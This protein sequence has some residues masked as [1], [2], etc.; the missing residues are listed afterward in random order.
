LNADVAIAVIL[1]A[2]DPKAL[3][4]GRITSAKIA[5]INFSDRPFES[6][7]I[8]ELKPAG[9]SVHTATHFVR[10]IK[11]GMRFSVLFAARE[12]SDF[13]PLPKRY[14][15]ATFLLTP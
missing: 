4:R 14:F 7:G 11:E 9:T 1:F 6:K 8:L 10:L 5:S 2:V 3:R 13:P 15:L 12:S